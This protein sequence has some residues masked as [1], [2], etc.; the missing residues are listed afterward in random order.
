MLHLGD[1]EGKNGTRTSLSRRF[2]AICFV[3][4]A[5][6]QRPFL[7]CVRRVAVPHRNTY[8]ATLLSPS[9]LRLACEQP[10]LGT[11]LL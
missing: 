7:G 11:W 5:L 2:V 6:Y 3:F 1:T 10:L 9:S 8:A 4:A